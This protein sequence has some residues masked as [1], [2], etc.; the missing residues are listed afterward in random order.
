MKIPISQVPALLLCCASLLSAQ[1][2]SRLRID[3]FALDESVPAQIHLSGEGGSFD[4]IPGKTFELPYGSYS[5]SV[6]MRGFAA[7]KLSLVVD[8][9]HQV[10]TVGLRLGAPD[11]V[12]LDPCFIYGKVT[13]PSAASRIKAVELFGSYSAE[14]SLTADGSYEIRNLACGGDYL[15]I[16]MAPGKM[17]KTLVVQPERATK[18]TDID[19]TPK[20]QQAP[21]K[22]S[23]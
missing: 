11:D 10:V 18:H 3:V 2:T 9:P 6:F 19:L 21:S 12:E 7:T 1:A 4:A 5:L 22:P 8:Q 17:L 23:P 16:V 13:P 20:A 14:V 15:L